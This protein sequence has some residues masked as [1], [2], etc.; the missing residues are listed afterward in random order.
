MHAT[1]ELLYA[2]FLTVGSIIRVIYSRRHRR[3][4]IA[5]QHRSRADTALIGLTGLGMCGPLVAL[6]TNWL[7]FADYR[8]PLAL[9]WA[10]VI[11]FCVAV[12]LLGASH[13]ALGRNWSPVL[14][15]TKTHS[16]V[17]T[18]V[19]RS[20]RHPMYTAHMLWAVG[21]VLLVHNWVAGPATLLFFI[22]LCVVR[23]PREERMMRER[24]GDEYRQY[25][26]RSGCLLPR[27][28]R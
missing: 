18:G 24:F 15:I 23:I 6:F 19:Y 7:D 26:A 1:L 17:T 10:G 4:D 8:A 3:D 2:M 5:L 16:L 28:R 9:A 20:M 25:S 13:A 12:W 14:Q 22:P 11:L 27:L 21:Q